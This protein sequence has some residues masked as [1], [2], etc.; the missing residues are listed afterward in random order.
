MASRAKAVAMSGQRM[1]NFIGVA[2]LFW[3]FAYAVL[4]VHATLDPTSSGRLISEARLIAT[5]AGTALLLGIL[6]LWERITV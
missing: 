3:L 2:A 4:T 1:T 6:L 5:A